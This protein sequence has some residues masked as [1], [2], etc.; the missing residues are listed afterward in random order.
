MRR[1]ES[2][3]STDRVWLVVLTFLLSLAFVAPAF[4]A[5]WGSND[6]SENVLAEDDE[7]EKFEYEVEDES[8]LDLPLSEFEAR[9]RMTR[10]LAKSCLESDRRHLQRMIPRAPPI[11]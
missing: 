10:L 4:A 8:S 11:G 5:D 7:G 2:R 6:L 1:S 3:R 9:V